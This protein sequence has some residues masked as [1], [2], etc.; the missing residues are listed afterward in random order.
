MK[1][2]HQKYIMNFLFH[3]AATLEIE[4]KVNDFYL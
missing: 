3:L 4:I 2:F 1:H